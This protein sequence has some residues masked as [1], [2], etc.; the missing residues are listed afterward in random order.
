[1]ENGL[2]QK[3][4]I[5]LEPYKSQDFIFFTNVCL[6]DLELSAP[7]LSTHTEHVIYSSC[8]RHESC[9]SELVKTLSVP[10]NIIQVMMYISILDHMLS[11]S[12][13]YTVSEG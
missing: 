10:W 8:I 5:L 6:Y 3:P 13:A 9:N 1:M 2:Q 12:D 4:Y 11:N 7:P